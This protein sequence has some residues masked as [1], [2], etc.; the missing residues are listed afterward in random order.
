MWLRRDLDRRV[1]WYGYLVLLCTEIPA[2]KSLC[3]G[4]CLISLKLN[5]QRFLHSV[6]PCVWCDREPGVSYTRFLRL[7]ENSLMSIELVLCVGLSAGW[8]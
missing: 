5:S 2:L 7:R 6:L 3:V 8:A 4:V 1:I